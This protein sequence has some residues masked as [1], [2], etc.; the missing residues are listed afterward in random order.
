MPPVLEREGILERLAA[1]KEEIIQEGNMYLSY[2]WENVRTPKER[3][4]FEELV[5]RFKTLRFVEKKKELVLKGIEVVSEKQKDLVSTRHKDEYREIFMKIAG[6]FQ[7]Y[8]TLESVR[9]SH[10]A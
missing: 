5:C 7:L 9:R 10:T 8:K 2:I 6:L 4:S 3:I 1:Q